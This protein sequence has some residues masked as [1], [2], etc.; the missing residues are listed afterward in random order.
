M[1]TLSLRRARKVTW[2]GSV[3][4][5]FATRRKQGR[6]LRT[7]LKQWVTFFFKGNSSFP[8][9]ESVTVFV[10]FLGVVNYFCV[11]CVSH[12]VFSTSVE[13]WLQMHDLHVKKI[14]IP[15]RKLPENV[16][17]SRCMLLLLAQIVIKK[18]KNINISLNQNVS[19][20]DPKTTVTW[21]FPLQHCLKR[22]TFI[23]RLACTLAKLL[24]S[25]D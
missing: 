20:G 6:F 15:E 19:I 12:T 3:L 18:G 14:R 9:P 7:T 13:E 24:Q 21:A 22:E 25:F 2:R 11:L 17:N 16:Q 5:S 4:R 1:P 23:S 10:T 8:F